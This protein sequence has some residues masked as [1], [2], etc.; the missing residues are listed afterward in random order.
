[1]NSLNVYFNDI[2]RN[3]SGAL[4]SIDVILFCLFKMYTCIGFKHFLKSFS[5]ET[6]S[7]LFASDSEKS[8]VR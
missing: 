3:L 5:C 1:M 8:L 6:N 4:S 2:E 7:V